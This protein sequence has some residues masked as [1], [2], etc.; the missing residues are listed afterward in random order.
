MASDHRAVVEKLP[1]RDSLGVHIVQN[2]CKIITN[3][4]TLNLA[5][6]C[7][8]SLPF[9]HPRAPESRCQ[10]RMQNPIPKSGSLTSTTWETGRWA[11]W[12]G[13]SN[14]SKRDPYCHLPLELKTYFITF[15]NIRKTIVSERISHPS[16]GVDIHCCLGACF[17]YAPAWFGSLAICAAPR[18]WDSQSAVQAGKPATD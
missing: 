5:S 18:K 9:S 15:Y 7:P 6:P 4:A 13:L 8:I 12:E 16:C 17:V 10:H 2:K 1:G 14:V 3:R 11:A